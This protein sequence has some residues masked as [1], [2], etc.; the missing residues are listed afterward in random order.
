MQI[1]MTRG[2]VGEDRT[3]WLPGTVHEASEAFARTLFTRGAAVPVGE[4]APAAPAPLT[5]QVIENRAIVPASRDP[6]PQPRRR[7][8]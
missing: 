3:D 7:R 1:R 2:V 8:R 6:Q 4:V 5:T